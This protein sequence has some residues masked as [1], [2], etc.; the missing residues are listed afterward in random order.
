MVTLLIDCTI[1]YNDKLRLS[2][3][4]LSPVILLHQLK[5]HIFPFEGD[6]GEKINVLRTGS[7]REWGERDEHWWR[8]VE[9]QLHR[10]VRLHHATLP[11]IHLQPPVLLLEEK[12]E[13]KLGVKFIYTIPL[14]EKRG[15]KL[16]W[17]KKSSHLCSANP[18]K[19]CAPLAPFL[20]K[21]QAI[22]QHGSHLQFGTC[23]GTIPVN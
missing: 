7:N 2:F 6:R 14:I 9:V 12:D 1:W 20:C 19:V 22:W 16:N 13:G 23:C 18:V 5:C 3:V 15:S 17:K 4:N 21:I 11:A 10:L 8:Q